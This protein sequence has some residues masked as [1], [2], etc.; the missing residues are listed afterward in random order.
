MEQQARRGPDGR[1]ARGCVPTALR[2]VGHAISGLNWAV[3]TSTGFIYLIVFIIS[4]V[5]VL[6]RYFLNWPSSWAFEVS[7]GLCGIQYCL[8]AGNTHRLGRHIRIEVVYLLL[9]RRLQ[10][11]CDVLA[12]VIVA[13]ITATIVYGGSL[14][15]ARAVSIW[16]TTGSAFDSPAPTFMK[17]AIPVGAGLILLQSLVRLAGNFSSAEGGEHQ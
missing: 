15:A 1:A 7:I 9:P 2:A 3:G 11:A 5:E 4:F 6:R 13:V 16:Q 14:Q 8:A 17:L 12:E 10:R